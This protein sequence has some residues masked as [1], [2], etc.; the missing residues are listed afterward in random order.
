M[1]ARVSTH[2][3]LT[4]ERHAELVTFLCR[5][6][7]RAWRVFMKPSLYLYDDRDHDRSITIEKQAGELRI[8]FEFET[9]YES[10]IEIL[11]RLIQ[12]DREACRMSIGSIIDGREYLGEY[13]GADAI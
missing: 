8:R 12:L 4:R 7:P 5:H 11:Q 6:N 2:D 13:V 9:V 10:A 3:P 1:K